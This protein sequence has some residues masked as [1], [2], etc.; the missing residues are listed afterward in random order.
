MAKKETKDG[1]IGKVIF[2]ERETAKME[3]ISGEFIKEDDVGI[4]VAYVLRGSLYTRRF[5]WSKISSAYNVKGEKSITIVFKVNKLETTSGTV[6][7]DNNN[8]AIISYNS[9]GKDWEERVPYASSVSV[10]TKESTGSGETV[11]E[12]SST[13]KVE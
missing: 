5:P 7:N 2:A 8:R 9:R 4:T 13:E 6:I 10:F 3:T 1:I 12:E 11:E